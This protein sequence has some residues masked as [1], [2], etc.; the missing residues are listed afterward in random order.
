MEGFSPTEYAQE[1]R[2]KVKTLIE[3]IG[4]VKEWHESFFTGVFIGCANVEYE[5]RGRLNAAI[6]LLESVDETYKV[7][8]ES[9]RE[10]DLE[11][12]LENGSVPEGEEDGSRR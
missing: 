12:A 2:D 8:M 9:M 7:A 5:C 1:I 6:L 11:R 4:V 3:N 10:T